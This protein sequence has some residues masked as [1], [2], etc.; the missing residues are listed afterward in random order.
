M[1]ICPQ[2]FGGTLTAVQAAEAIAAGWRSRAPGDE[3]TLAPISGGGA[4]FL[5]VLSKSAE[6]GITV[7]ATV[8]D[9]LGREVP[10]MVLL[11]EDGSGLTAYVEAT[12]AAGLHLL[13]ASERRPGV[14]SSRGVGELIGVA[15]EEK[16]D[17]VVV[18]VGDLATND[19][20]AGMLG[21]LGAGPPEE[22]CRGGAA[23]AEA[24]RD[25]LSGLGALRERLSGVEL[26]LVTQE[27]LPLLGLQGTSA[28][29][30]GA[31]GADPQE[32][33]ILEHALSRFRH[34]ADTVCPPPVDLLSGTPRRLDRAAGAGAG[35]GLGYGLLLLGARR[36]SAAGW[37]F[38]AWG[39][40][41]LL[42][43]TDLVVTGEGCLDWRSA[44][45]GVVAEVAEAAGRRGLPV[46]AVAGTVEVG[47]RDTMSMGLSATYAVAERPAE[48]VAALA[49]PAG[50]LSARV[51][52]VAATWSP[53]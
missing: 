51:A 14:T 9:P 34:L 49:D 26:V 25:A 48:V 52:R 39:L 47:R 33:Q 41:S 7:A 20:G 17:R 31:R 42:A 38:E 46:V 23:L 32:A 1:L 6:G 16:A 21:A 11:V 15:L 12:Q 5:E 10:G 19:G 40:P 24:D 44:G 53:G 35:G 45:Q 4:D 13:S 8:N 2:R 50:A 28:A 43:C 22:L 27:E 29:T 18:A 37:C 3:L 36:C 30:A